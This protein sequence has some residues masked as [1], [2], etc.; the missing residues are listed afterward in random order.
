LFKQNCTKKSK[1]SGLGMRESRKGRCTGDYRKQWVV[2]TSIV[3][4][5]LAMNE[6]RSGVT[7]KTFWNLENTLRIR[8]GSLNNAQA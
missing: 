4:W 3:L 5:T 8:K 1:K 2:G 6:A 7:R